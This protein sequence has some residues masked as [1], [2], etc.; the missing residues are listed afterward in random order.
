MNDRILIRRKDKKS[1]RVEEEIGVKIRRGACC[2]EHVR[3]ANGTN[4][5]KSASAGFQPRSLP[6]FSRKFVTGPITSQVD[7]DR[8][9]LVKSF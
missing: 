4:R 8:I 9:T 7:S 1:K 5:E 3:L 6:P 2:D